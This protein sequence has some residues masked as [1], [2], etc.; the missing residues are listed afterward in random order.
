[1]HMHERIVIDDSVILNTLKC[2]S[3]VS[4]PGGRDPQGGPEDYTEG[5][6]NILGNHT[7]SYIV[8]HHSHLGFQGEM[9]RRGHFS[10]LLA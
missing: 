7:S 2:W 4:Q 9:S 6:P 8:S 3:W 5:S 10:K 1:M